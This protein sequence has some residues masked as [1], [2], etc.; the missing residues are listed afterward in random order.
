MIIAGYGVLSHASVLSSPA[1]LDGLA[2]S[3]CPSGPLT[4]R[5][6][7]TAVHHADASTCPGTG[8]LSPC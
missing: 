1:A 8:M 2:G 3:R 5:L 7:T 6:S 4:A